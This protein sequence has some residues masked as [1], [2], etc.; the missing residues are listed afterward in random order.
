MSTTRYSDGITWQAAG[1]ARTITRDPRL[2]P[3]SST[4]VWN[5]PIANSA[6]FEAITDPAT[7]SLLKSTGVN[8]WVNQS[9]YSHPIYQASYG[10]PVTDCIVGAKP[11]LNGSFHAPADAIPATGNDRHF[12]VID[13]EGHYVHETYQAVRNSS[14]AMTASRHHTIDLFGDGVGPYNGVRAYGGSAIGGIIRAWEVDPTHPNYTGV[15]SHAIAGALDGSQMLY[16]AGGA[17]DYDHQTGYWRGRGYVWPATE[18][19]GTASGGYTGNVPMGGYYAIPPSVDLATLGL[20]TNSAIMLARALQDYGGY[21]TDGTTATF[22]IASVEVGAPPD[23]RAELV[24]NNASDLKK[25][26]N[27]LRIVTNNTVTTPN[28]GALG[29]ARRQPLT[30]DLPP[31]P[32]YAT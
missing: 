22:C 17:D 3:F 30:P 23:F 1:P 31:P 27:Q 7:T 20:A 28:G 6:T 26:R 2:H 19:D 18:Q 4:S 9:G 14:T 12:H 29:A 13:P 5:L 21:V 10:D 15:I 24:S 11:A 8:V 16:I 25:I 32:R